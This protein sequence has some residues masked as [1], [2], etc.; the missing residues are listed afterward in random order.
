M[1][2]T[3]DETPLDVLKSNSLNEIASVAAEPCVSILMPTHRKGRE[4]QQA[5]IRLKRTV[6]M[7]CNAIETRCSAS[8]PHSPQHEGL[9]DIVSRLLGTQVASD[10]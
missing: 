10:K 4:T 5:A 7:S 3:T 8:T 9:I 1:P 6:V 2:T